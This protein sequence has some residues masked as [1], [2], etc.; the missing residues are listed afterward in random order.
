[1]KREDY[2]AV[3]VGVVLLGAGVY[4]GVIKG[5]KG[6][7]LSD[8]VTIVTFSCT[9]AGSERTKQYV[10][11]GVKGDDWVKANLWGMGGPF[12]LP[13]SPSPGVAHSYKPDTDFIQKPRLKLVE[14]FFQ[15]GHTYS[16]RV[17]VTTEPTSLDSAY[18]FWD[19]DGPDIKIVH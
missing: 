19:G 1:M 4:Y 5:G 14:D 6:I 18:I 3:G 9:Y 12:I 8:T 15:A 11:W 17:W 2:V 7:H 16:T 13:R 10:C